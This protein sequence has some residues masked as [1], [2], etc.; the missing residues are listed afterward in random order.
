[1][2]HAALSPLI[3][4]EFDE[5]LGAS[6]GEDR[7]GTGLSVL[8]ALARLDVASVR[9]LVKLRHQHGCARRPRPIVLPAARRQSHFR[10]IVSD[11]VIKS[12]THPPCATQ[13][14]RA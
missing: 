6:I 13:W 8:S 10:V 14:A 2:I 9:L 4:S 12:R 3:G 1:M 11:A 5:F 7:N